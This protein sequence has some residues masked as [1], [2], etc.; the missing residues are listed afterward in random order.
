MAVITQHRRLFTL[1]TPLGTDAMLVTGF[2]GREE[3]SRPFSFTLDL[4]S[5]NLAVA[6]ADLVGMAV[7]WTVN[8]PDEGPRQFHGYV[9]RLVAGPQARDSIRS[10]RAEVVPWL[11]FLTRTTDCRI[12]QNKTVPDIIADVFSRFGFSAATESRLKATYPTREYCVQYR[13][14]AFD[15]VSRLM[16]EYGIYYYFT[17]A[18]DKHT[19]VL[20]DDVSGY[21]DCDP[22]KEVEY[23]PELPDAEVVSEWD[24]AF[25]YRSGKVTHTDYNFTTPATNLLTDA[26]STKPLSGL[27]KFELF[28]YPGRYAVAG[29]G[30]GLAKV[31]I[32]EVEAGYDTASGISR[33]SSFAAGGK[34]ALTGHPADAGNYVFV[35]VEHAGTETQG[36]RAGDQHADYRNSFLCIPADVP[37]RPARV[38]PRPVVQGP[39]P[40]V[41]VGPSGEEI[42]T[43]KYGRV[44]VQFFWDRLGQKNENSSCWMRVAEMWAGKQWGM[45]FTPRIGQEVLVEFL[46][47]DPDQ[48][49]VTGRVYNAEQMP[50]YALP[51]NMTQSGIKTRSTK[52]GGTDDFNELRFEDNK[53]KEDIYFHAQKDFHRLVEN[54]DDLKVLHDQT[55]TIKN[56]R[57]LEVQEGYEK[58]TIDK[59]D[60]ER[61]VSKGNDTLTVS[62]GNRTVT[63]SKGNL[64][65]TISKGNDTL[66]VADGQR[67]VVVNKD[68]VTTVKTGNHKLEVTAGDSLVKIGNNLTFDVTTSITLKVGSNQ[69][70]I[71]Q[72]GVAIT[73]SK[74]AISVGGSSLAMDPGKTAI[75]AAVLDLHADGQ[76]KVSGLSVEVA[77]D[78][79]GK[80]SGLMV[81][82]DG[83]AGVE[84]KGALV[85]IN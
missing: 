81:Q 37:F 45:V 10:Y 52:E 33:C 79:L 4:L 49:I 2:R 60:R 27:S 31:R 78:M 84:M 46:E 71:D 55:I 57:T 72:K 51:A 8:M 85:E 6:P 67:T 40:A 58:I 12:Y 42:Y 16:E 61:T 44:I 25:E 48:P 28:D 19:L 22:H 34:F 36:I 56:N 66:T 68:F 73:A 74:L 3:L 53:G 7:G 62:E 50:P 26:S 63:I 5:D 54:D 9:R 77:G 29:D 20:A 75:S 14:T 64:E 35:A 47:G 82:L 17:F 38:T 41:V 11:W 23:R 43:D 69:I 39:Q 1:S 65:T 15:F 32:E 80:V 21:F 76:T 13:E 18:A 59:G 24:R 70:V 83:T 30:T